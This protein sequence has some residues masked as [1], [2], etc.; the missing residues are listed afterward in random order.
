MPILSQP[1]RRFVTHSGFL[2]AVAALSGGQRIA[3]VMACVPV[4]DLVRA[5]GERIARL[6][7]NTIAQWDPNAD[8]L[9]RRTGYDRFHAVVSR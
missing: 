4:A 2:G 9:V 3:D 8:G 5:A 1:R 7:A 6:T